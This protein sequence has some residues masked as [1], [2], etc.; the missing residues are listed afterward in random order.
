MASSIAKA[1]LSVRSIR[2]DVQVK[3]TF[4]DPFV[5]SVASVHDD[6]S[7]LLRHGS[8]CATRPVLPRAPA[9]GSPSGGAKYVTEGENL[10]ENVVLSPLGQISIEMAT[11]SAV[12]LVSAIRRL[13]ALRG[14]GHFPEYAQPASLVH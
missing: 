2:P 6:R 3:C 13:E 8:H 5:Q 7:R 9:W 14:R 4:K 12:L 10:R 1:G 11:V